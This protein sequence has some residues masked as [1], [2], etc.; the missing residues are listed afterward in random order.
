L[1]RVYIPKKNGKLRPLGI[2]TMKDRA[3]QAIYLLALDPVAEVLAD[4]NSYG[5][6]RERAC[7]DAIEQC[8][9]L[10][11]KRGSATWVLEGDIR[12]CF[13]RISHDWLLDHVPLPREGMRIV[14]RWLQCGYMEKQVFHH[15]EAG[16]PQ[17]GIISPVLANIALDGLEAALQHR[18]APTR[19]MAAANKVHL[20]RYADDFI[21]TGTS[22]ELLEE[23]VRPFIASFMAER[24]LQ[25]SDEKTL[26]THIADGFDFLGQN[27]RRYQNGRL[28]IIPSR[29]N[30]K[31]FLD[32]VREVI[33]GHKQAT[34]GNLIRM[35]NR[36]IRGWAAYHR[37][38]CSKRTFG[39][40]DHVIFGLLRRWCRRRH[41]N[42]SLAWIRAKYFTYVPG[43]GGG[44]HWVFFGTLK[45][46]RGEQRTL[47]LRRTSQTAI[48]RHTKVRGAL[49]PYDP[50]WHG[51]LD[52]RHRR[53][54]HRV[55]PHP[56][57][58]AAHLPQQLQTGT[59]SL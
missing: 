57:A 36:K 7:A 30:V 37:H 46:E 31:A 48:R 10:L 4:W 17:G 12:A 27:V 14:H 35:L 45:R 50:E 18:F 40:V 49:N 29:R 28:I 9:K 34:A 47:T 39:R 23:E 52:R 5:F 58:P 24:G 56:A 44:N 51:Y 53:A 13:D 55:R 41:P 21:V 25:L 38:V 15:T 19:R 6:R 22:R 26:V 33:K 54:P 11:A 1:R 32:N 16:T 43:P 2:P 3:M 42:K 8:F 59:A 20:V